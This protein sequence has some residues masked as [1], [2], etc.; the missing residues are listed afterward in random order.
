MT[1]VMISVGKD[2]LVRPGSFDALPFSDVSKI[3]ELVG[4]EFI[5]EKGIPQ[6]ELLDYFE[7]LGWS[8][9][10]S[11]PDGRRVISKTGPVIIPVKQK[12]EIKFWKIPE[13]ATPE[14]MTGVKRL[15]F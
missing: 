15:S 9:D 6:K 4:Q 7:K 11:M 12:L 13:V 1:K 5:L 2:G 3:L 10:Q 8:V 14:N